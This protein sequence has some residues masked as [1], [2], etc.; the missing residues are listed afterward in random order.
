MRL[1][2]GLARLLL[3]AGLVMVVAGVVLSDDGDDSPFRALPPS[4]PVRLVVPS[5]G[6]RA[7][8]E[9]VAVSA[10]RVLDPPED[11]ERV[12]WWEA[13][14]RPGEMAGQTV[15]TGHAVHTGGGALDRLRDLV[16]GERVDLR[17]EQGL[18]R[19]Q[20][21]AVRSL[22]RDRVAARTA[23]LFGQE[24]G[25]GRLVVVSCTG[26]DGSSYR[27]N[28]VVTAEPLGEPL[29]AAAGTDALTAAG[30]R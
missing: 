6:V 22:G 28:V 29:A 24:G 5:L 19:Y 30:S 7:A 12:G 13:S 26:W 27:R 15:L 23:D 18:M 1:L 2:G 21:T 10:D 16:A 9:P 17:T 8:V 3:A 20:V 4:A 25:D 14:A 11:V